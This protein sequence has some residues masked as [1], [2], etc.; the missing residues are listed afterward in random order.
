MHALA[1]REPK[2]TPVEERGCRPQAVC[3]LPS[4]RLQ[5]R[6]SPSAGTEPVPAGSWLATPEDET[7]AGFRW[8]LG[9]EGEADR[10]AGD[11][12]ESATVGEEVARVPGWLA[13]EVGPGRPAGLLVERLATA[14]R[15]A[16]VPLW[17]PNVDREALQL[18]LRLPGTFWVDGSAVP[19]TD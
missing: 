9:S 7:E 11:V 12:L 17:V 14:A 5:G 1:T 19:Q 10:W 16:R 2:P 15:R 8:R 18:L 4:G 6:W 3:E 13:A